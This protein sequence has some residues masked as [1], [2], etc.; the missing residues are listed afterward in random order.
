MHVGPHSDFTDYFVIA[1]CLTR[2]QMRAVTVKISDAAKALGS[3]RLGLEGETSDHW[4]LLDYGDVII[5]LFS[6]QT[7]AY[8]HLEQLWGDAQTVKW[9]AETR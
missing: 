8:Y 3:T 1:S 6:P 4:R 5:H 7:R 9:N 2:A